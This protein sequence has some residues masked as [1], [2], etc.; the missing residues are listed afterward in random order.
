MRILSLIGLA[1][2]LISL[3][4][5]QTYELRESYYGSGGPVGASG[6]N[7]ELW[8][9]ATGQ[10]AITIVSGGT[11]T[12]QQGFY[13]GDKMFLVRF[14]A[15]DYQRAA[16]N[17][18]DSISL[19]DD[20]LK[21]VVHYLYRGVW[22]NDTIGTGSNNYLEVWV[23]TVQSGSNY[24]YERV[25]VFESGAG[26][27]PDGDPCDPNF[28]RWARADT[29][30]GTV[31]Q[32]TQDDADSVVVDFWEQ[33]RC[34]VDVVFDPPDPG[35]SPY[36]GGLVDFVDYRRFNSSIS[37]DDAYE[38]GEIF[39]QWCD[40]GNSSYSSRLT[41]SDTTTAGWITID[42]HD[43][44]TSGGLDKSIITEIKYQKPYQAAYAQT[45]LW[46]RYTLFG[47]PLYPREDTTTY[48]TFA[49]DNG[50]CA[51]GAYD[52]LVDF[53]EQDIVLYDDMHDICDTPTDSN[54][55]TWETW[56]RVMRYYPQVGGYKRYRG[57]GMSDNPHRFIPGF[58]FWGNQTHCDSIE[59]DTWGV[60]A[61]T[62]DS[63]EVALGRYDG[64]NAY[65][66]YNMMANP[67]Y[68][69][70]DA[71]TIKVDV[72]QWRVRNVTTSNTVNIAQ[73]VSNHWI[74]NPIYVYRKTEGTWQY[75][76]LNINVS[77][78]N[79]YI[80]E[81]EGFWLNIDPACTDSL[82]LIMYVESQSP[83]S[84]LRIASGSDHSEWFVRLSCDMGDEGD[85]FNDAGYSSV[86]EKTAFEPTDIM[87]P[88]DIPEPMR[89][90]YMVGEKN[91][92]SYYYNEEM[93]VYFWRV[94]LEPGAQRGKNARL[95][96]NLEHIPPEYAVMI[97]I[98]GYEEV[99]LRTRNE[100]TLES[101]IKPVD[102]ELYVYPVSSPIARGETHIP[103]KFFMSSVIPNP[104]NT[105]ATVEFGIP[106]GQGDMT[107]IEILD[108]SGHKIKTLWN[109][110]TS[111]GYHTVIWDGT[112]ETGR[113][114]PA[115]TYLC[116][117][118][119]PKFIRTRRAILIK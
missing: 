92:A 22:R 80:Y 24:W 91:L 73:A 109:K 66:R 118:V 94:R 49:E 15:K 28:H 90:Y 12:D 117:M 81:W 10:T 74:L 72:S 8:G 119:H 97:K 42:D 20:T 69:P 82:H 114:V 2:L 45:I 11:Y 86:M 29:S 50:C 25:A 101:V 104:F 87:N 51:A 48:K 64:T 60:L 14:F 33:Y 27:C 34:S 5:G 32:G 103:D 53:G 111:A 76:P 58:G 55:G 16:D 57:P 59:I 40:R 19:W 108:L 93:D 3:A 35:S 30:P 36:D 65:T 52:G 62:T 100:L 63:F 54:C 31:V 116:R 43:F 41:F 113:P 85:Y 26:T 96:W 37:D 88:P 23:D 9:S 77:N 7:F 67:F 84:L 78:A 95:F 107:T 17:D 106:S 21:V 39:D 83:V 75:V 70:D 115:G 46:R 1:L 99:D 98:P 13:H 102:M 110:S 71:D 112:D 47:V 61:D 68:D 56:Y 18:A 44:G 38:H 4:G 6:G 105:S 89:L 79:V